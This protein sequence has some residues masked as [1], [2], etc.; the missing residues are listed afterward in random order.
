MV[1]QVA[2]ERLLDGKKQL[3]LEWKD[4]PK[5]GGRWKCT[6]EPLANLDCDERVGEWM[7]TSK[8]EKQRRMHAAELIGIDDAYAEVAE[9][10]AVCQDANVR[11]VEM[12]ISGDWGGHESILEYICELVGLDIDQV[13]FN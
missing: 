11:P 3:L 9:V 5:G 6:W 10:S 4:G 13:V 2:A 1:K 8:A 7:M 12:D